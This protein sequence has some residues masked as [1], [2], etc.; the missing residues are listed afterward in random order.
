M[1]RQIRFT[2]LLLA[3]CL[4]LNSVA[5]PAAAEGD[6]EPT[7]ETTEVTT[8]PAEELP[9]PAEDGSAPTEEATEPAEEAFVPTEG[10]AEPTPRYK[11]EGNTLLITSSRELLLLS[12]LDPWEYCDL[13]LTFSPSDEKNAGFDLLKKEG[14]LQF[15]GLGSEEYPFRGEIL[16]AD[17]TGP[18]ALNRP[19]FNAL[20]DDAK[21]TGL[22]LESH[23]QGVAEGG[24]LA[25]TVTHGQGGNTWTITLTQ[26][27]PEENIEVNLLPLIF[28]LENNAE[29]S[30]DVTD[31]SGLS[32]LG[33]GYLCAVMGENAQLTLSGIDTIPAVAGSGDAVGG[34]VGLM[35]SGA[36][37]TV[38]GESIT[39]SGVTGNW[40]VGGIVGSATDPLLSLPSVVGCDGAVVSGVN[41]GG[42]IGRL[43]YMP[44]DQ[45]LSVTLS[46]LTLEGSDNAG[47]L[48][49]VLLRDAGTL[50]LD[51]QV[52]GIVLIEG[53]I[54][55]GSLFGTY[56]TSSPENPLILNGEPIAEEA[57]LETLAGLVDYPGKLEIFVTVEDAQAIIDS[58]L[59][60]ELR[61]GEMSPLWW[62]VVSGKLTAEE[63]AAQLNAYYSGATETDPAE[64]TEPTEESEAT[65]PTEETQTQETDN[66]PQE[67]TPGE[68]DSSPETASFSLQAEDS[69]GVS[70]ADEQVSAHTLTN[71]EEANPNSQEAGTAAPAPFN[72]ESLLSAYAADLPSSWPENKGKYVIN[73][74]FDL[75]LLSYLDLNTYITGNI[76]FDITDGSL[77][78]LT[79]TEYTNNNPHVP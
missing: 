74:S 6:L 11:P 25:K 17:G 9:V 77:Y 2:A 13:N 76:I 73:S 5:F 66:L 69:S 56:Y 33:S 61:P 53:A 15:Q 12:Y 3:V 31:L 55:C 59:N 23:V 21:I 57:E 49:G 67:P 14:D 58:I 26:P 54:N 24:L 28:N 75:V 40:N 47:G 50:T 71:S 43:T 7:Q 36:S 46:N 63:L 70:L 48:V 68:G 19:L 27:E 37:L 10:A 78:D 8:V 72:L 38:M 35:K 16:F 52:E 39:V 41:V 51:A 62:A 29:V 45:A 32:V 4:L 30:L 42:L 64:E 60:A 18:I 79:K 22:S 1:N 34:L 65:E 44:G 20:S